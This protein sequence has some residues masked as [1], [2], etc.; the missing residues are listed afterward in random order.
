MNQLGNEDLR[1]HANQIS[2]E[3][4]KIREDKIVKLQ[5]R[6]REKLI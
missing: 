2:T 5:W 4:N 3:L 1:I 6:R